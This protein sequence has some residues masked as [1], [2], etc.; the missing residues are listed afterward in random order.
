MQI[1]SHPKIPELETEIHIRRYIDRAHCSRYRGKCQYLR[2]RG[3]TGVLDSVDPELEEDDRILN[4]SSQRS[5][6]PRKISEEIFF[7]CRMEKNLY[8]H[9]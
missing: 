4:H 5:N 1:T 6:Q 9:C 2:N 8:P 3:E 7:L